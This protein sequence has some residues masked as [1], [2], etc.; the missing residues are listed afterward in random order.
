MKLVFSLALRDLLME[1]THLI[2][3]AAILAS[4][5]VPLMV[6]FGVKNGIY[7]A[8]ISRLLNDPGTTRIETSGNMSFS[9]ADVIEV[10]GW[11]QT[12]FITAKTRSISDFVNVR[13]AESTNIRNAILVSSGTGDPTLPKD[14]TLGPHE[15]AIS[16]VLARQL[17]I[18]VDDAIQIFTQA[19]QRPRQLMIPLKVV[20]V[21]PDE[22]ASGRSIFANI[23]VLDLV[24]AFYDGYALPDHGIF[25]GRDLATRTPEYEG[26]R[27]FAQNIYDLAILQ[28]RIEQFFDV[29]TEARTAEVT[30]VLNLGRNLNI[31]L[32]LNVG[33]ASF[34]LAGAL[35]FGF[36]AEVVR[37]RRTIATLALL[38]VGSNRLWFFPVI[39]AILSAV[40]G[41]TISFVLFFLA[42]FFAENLFDSGLTDRGGLV[43]LSIPQMLAIIAVVFIFV[44]FTSYFAARIASRVDPAEVLRQGA[45]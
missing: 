18:S 15:T 11:E 41:L 13:L 7:D 39:Q 1:R 36:W 12:G 4:V 33:V 30:N 5:L 28:S 2:C 8:L 10:R 32:L 29:R 23:D 22:R 21:L 35:T 3:N 16:A 27:I 42:A 45:T 19:T 37:K 9:P 44:I 38:G 20:A 34:G 40:A 6:V 43:V 14:L 26:L 17:N 31:A 24:E 25:E